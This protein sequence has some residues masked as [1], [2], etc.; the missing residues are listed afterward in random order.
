MSQKLC[1]YSDLCCFLD[2]KWYTALSLGSLTSLMREH[3]TSRSNGS[4]VDSLSWYKLRESQMQWTRLNA[5]SSEPA[6]LS[7]LKCEF[8]CCNSSW[9]RKRRREDNSWLCV[10]ARSAVYRWVYVMLGFQVMIQVVCLH[11]R[12]YFSFITISFILKDPITFLTNAVKNL[13]SKML[14]WDCLSSGTWW[15]LSSINQD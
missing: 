7:T 4:C 5:S 9:R 10:P 14:N 3:D 2:T 12:N 8:L 11:V 15:Q 1:L 6:L 13:L